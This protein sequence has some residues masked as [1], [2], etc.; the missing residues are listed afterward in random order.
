MITL[1]DANATPGFAAGA[2]AEDGTI[3]FT[4]L[5][6]LAAPPETSPAEEPPV[7]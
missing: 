6:M 4:Q 1:G 3:Y 5:F 2:W 7:P